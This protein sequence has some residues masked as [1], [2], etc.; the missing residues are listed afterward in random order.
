MSK[1]RDSSSNQIVLDR[2]QNVRPDVTEAY[3]V[4]MH[5]PKLRGKLK[6]IVYR[7]H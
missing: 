5:V 4:H 3:R 6:D 2:K 1:R 7:Q